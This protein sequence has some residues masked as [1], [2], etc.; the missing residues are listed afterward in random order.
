MRGKPTKTEKTLATAQQGKA[1]QRRDKRSSS[2][3]VVDQNVLFFTKEPEIE[4]RLARLTRKQSVDSVPRNF[5]KSQNSRSKQASLDER[6]AE[7][8]VKIPSR[9]K[10]VDDEPDKVCSIKVLE[11]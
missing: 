10:R 11:C 5:T 9:C 8:L 6:N 3:S 7:L 4:K 2:C 1:P